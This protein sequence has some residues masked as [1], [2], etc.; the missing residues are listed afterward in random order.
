MTVTATG[1]AGA[2]T[3]GVVHQVMEAGTLPGRTAVRDGLMD[4]PN[5]KAKVAV[6]TAV[7]AAWKMA[8]REY[9]LIGS[10]SE[11]RV[12]VL[13]W[14]SLSSRAQPTGVMAAQKVTSWA[15]KR[16]TVR[17]RASTLT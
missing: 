3:P 14:E 9:P 13:N 2:L 11:T 16:G 1:V 8:K 17:V 5:S 15:P 12:V 6:S 4:G 10:C 7:V